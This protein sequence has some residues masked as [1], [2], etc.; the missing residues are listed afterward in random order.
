MRQGL[1][2]SSAITECLSHNQVKTSSGAV[3]QLQGKINSAAMRS[4]GE[5][6]LLSPSHITDCFSLARSMGGLQGNGISM[7]MEVQGLL[8][9]PCSVCSS[10]T[11]TACQCSQQL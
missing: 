6:L 3:Y 8:S 10:G 9:S 1:W 7:Q 4:E 5:L 11:F 2:H